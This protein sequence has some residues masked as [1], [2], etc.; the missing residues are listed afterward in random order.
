MSSTGDKGKAKK[1]TLDQRKPC[2][3]SQG[4]MPDET[5]GWNLSRKSLSEIPKH[6]V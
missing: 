3:Y 5:G 6:I 2:N 4:D 1:A